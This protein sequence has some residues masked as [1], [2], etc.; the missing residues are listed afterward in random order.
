MQTNKFYRCITFFIFFLICFK[1]NCK[2]ANYN[3]QMKEL[4]SELRC[5]VCQN[6][7]LLE[8]DSELAKDIKKLIQE[9]LEAGQSEKEIK[10]F[11]VERYG[12]FILFNPLFK[13]SNIILWISPVLSLALIG[14]LA[15]RKARFNSRK[16]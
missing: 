16:R 7:S 1:I 14:F 4:A 15:L 9:K 3:Q 11:L 10:A 6:Q 2:E 8:S 12:E 13:P 5:M